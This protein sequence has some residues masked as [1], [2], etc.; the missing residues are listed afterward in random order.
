LKTVKQEEPIARSRFVD[1][2]ICKNHTLKLKRTVQV[3]R[4]K[5]CGET[6]KIIVIFVKTGRKPK[7]NAPSIPDSTSKQENKPEAVAEPSL[8]SWQQSSDSSLFGSTTEP[9]SGLAEAVFGKTDKQET[10]ET[11][12]TGGQ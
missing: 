6:Y 5:S 9:Y 7:S 10:S 1:C 11:G 2:P 8:P 3:G 4:C 12:S